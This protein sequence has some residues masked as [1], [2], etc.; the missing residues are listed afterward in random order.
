MLPAECR[1]LPSELEAVDALLDDP[2]FFEP[3][4]GFFD[5]GRVARRCRSR[6]ICG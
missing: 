1:G 5:A 6:R 3:F 4:R 2:A